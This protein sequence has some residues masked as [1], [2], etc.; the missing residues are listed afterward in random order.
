MTTDEVSIHPTAV[1][2]PQAQLE[3]GVFVGPYCVIGPEVRIGRGT[4][5]EANVHIVGWTT[6]GE[7][8]RFSPYSSVG[9]EPQD[10]TYKGE[11]TFVHI[12][13]RN[14]FREFITINRGTPKGGGVTSIGDDNYFM[15]YSHIAHDC[16]VGHRTVFINGA[17]LAGH[18]EVDDYA[19]VGAFSAV[20]QFCRI[21][22][23]SFIGGY[24]VITQDVCP[25]LRVAGSRPTLLYGINAIGLRRH[26]FTR[27]QIKTIKKMIKYLFYSELNTTQALEKIEQEIEPGPEREEILNFVKSSKRGLVKKVS[28]PWTED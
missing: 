13:H 28:E 15:A 27:E 9:T 8:C 10:V 21:G 16:R 19:T 24:S 12:G 25:Y 26:G 20:H 1:V 7:E 11:K 22:K 14:I 4:Y 2:H 6:I 5:L 17:T 23:Y 3:A 18:V